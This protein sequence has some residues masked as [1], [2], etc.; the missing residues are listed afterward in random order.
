MPSSERTASRYQQLL[1]WVVSGLL[2]V[3]I[4][5]VYAQATRFNFLGYDDPAFVFDNPV[6]RSGL[7]GQGIVW[8]FTDGPFGEWYPLAML[9]H[10]LDCELFGLNPHWHHLTSVLLHAA[11]AIGLFHVLRSMTGELWPS[12]FVAMLLAVHPQHVESV[13]WIAERRDVLSGLLFVLTLGA[14][15]DYVRHGRSWAGYALVAGALALGLLAKPMLVT[16]PA[17][18][19]LLDYWPLG[20]FG[21]ASGIPAANRTIERPG[22][23]RL[24]LEKIPLGVLAAADA[25]L[26]LRTHGGAGLFVAA[27][28]ARFG[29]AAVAYVK[30]MAKFFYPLDLAAFY[31]LAPSGPPAWQVLG[32]IAILIAVSTAAVIWRRRLPALFVGW[33]WYLG[34]LVPVLGLLNAGWYSSMADRYTYLP[35]IG[36]SIA[37]A[38]GASRLAVR[39]AAPRWLLPTVATIAMVLLAW[40]SVRQTSLW[41]DDEKL[42]RHSL[43]LTEDNAE[44]EVNLADALRRA[45]RLDEALEHY[46]LAAGF[47][48][49]APLLNNMGIT[50]LELGRFEEA[51]DQFRLV[52]QITPNSALRTTI[53]VG[54]CCARTPWTRRPKNSTWRSSTTAPSPWPGTIWPRCCKKRGR[55]TE[56]SP[57]SICALELDPSMAVAHRQVAALLAAQG[58]AGEAIAHYRAALA[59]SPGD[60][61]ARSGLE[62]LGVR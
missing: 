60:A 5:V 36:L 7:T 12:A 17:L 62:R 19:L 45:G 25:F 40:C 43:A 39:W 34:M 46:R 35:S 3:A 1:P 51:A 30:Y 26:T 41:G 10:M 33:F 9:S 29:N 61:D 23:W 57:T 27:W 11:A 49:N 13:V 53:S 54:R 18:L 42:W 2:F 47:A 55:S 4:A 44:A 52:I 16:V 48:T 50:L 56:P 59:L 38:W 21:R 20:R 24:V 6:V 28:P 8:A 58:R 37:L 32:A 15:L 31:P 22:V 14:Y